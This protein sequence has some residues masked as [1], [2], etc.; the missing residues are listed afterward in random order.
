MTTNNLINLN[1]SGIVIYDGAGNFFGRQLS[2]GAG[3]NVTNV[4][5]IFGNPTITNT[6]TIIW[7]E[8]TGIAQT[9]SSMNGYI[10]NNVSLI[11]FTLPESANIGDVIHVLGK[12]AGGFKIEQN[13]NQQIHVGSVSSTVGINGSISSINQYDTVELICVTSGTST[14]WT[15]KVTGNITVV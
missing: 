5:G 15:A 4:D 7:T 11:T 14:V 1:Q 10:A 9:M 8:I 12:G 13:A 6:S 2:V 3:L